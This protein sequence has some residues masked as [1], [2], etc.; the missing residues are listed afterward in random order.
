[1]AL[2]K[3]GLKRKTVEISG[4]EVEVR[5]LT[6]TEIRE[7]MDADN[8]D[9]AD[10]MAIAWGTSSTVEEA[11]EFLA[12]TGADDAGTLMREILELSGWSAEASKSS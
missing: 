1:M 7:I 3:I 5:S 12:N 4:Y 8:K 2:P 9:R 6:V 10:A 11:E